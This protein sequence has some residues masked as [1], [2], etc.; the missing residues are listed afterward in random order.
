MRNIAV[1][2]G[3]RANYG[4][5]LPVMQAVQRHPDLGLKLL[6]TGMHLDPSRGNTY[7]EIEKD[8]F[9]I[10]YK[11]PV[12]LEDGDGPAM[13]RALGNMIVSLTDVLVQLEP[14]VLLLLGDR[15]E[16]LAGAVAG[17]HCGIPVA[18]LHG[19]E[20]T[21]SIDEST[22]HAIS[23]FAHIHLAATED[24]AARLERMGED[25][26]RIFTVGSPGLDYILGQPKEPAALVRKEFGVPDGDKLL[27]VLQ[28]PVTSEAESAAQQ[29][30]ETMEAVLETGYTSVVI[31]PNTDAGGN[32]MIRVIES[33]STNPKPRIRQSVPY[34]TFLSLLAAAD[35]MIGNSS[36]AI[37]EAPSFG[38]PCINLGSRQQ[39]R[40]RGSNLIDSA[41]DRSAI[42]NAIR[43][44]LTNAA[45]RQA[46]ATRYNPYGD[47]HTGPR[48][49]SLLTTLDL[50]P[51]WLS[52]RNSY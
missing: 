48:V 52:K 15:G 3:T 30:R 11:I 4:R 27:I 18:H 20:I 31:Y 2:T 43:E 41:H 12:P 36:S 13:A 24:S 34:S 21:G 45:F 8:G 39:G 42:G 10:D 44:A 22:R 33:Y 49:A 9:A 25:Q 38:L 47:G 29:M 28:H 6:V 19:G 7:R 17:A 50:G 46:C 32:D 40:L 5:L 37:M 1:L 16:E 51:R 14:D 26:W 35:L 23:K